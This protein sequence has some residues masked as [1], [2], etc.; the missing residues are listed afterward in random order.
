MGDAVIEDVL[1]R[2]NIEG[3]RR[4]REW[5]APC[6]NKEHVDRHPSWRIRD[7]PG[8][9]R[10]GMHHCWP[11][12]FGGALDDLVMKVLNLTW[13]EAKEWLSGGAVE[14]DK[15]VAGGVEFKVQSALRAFHLPVGVELDP[16]DKWPSSVRKYAQGR[17]ITAE[18]VHHWGIGYAVEGRLGGR[19]VFVKR[20]NRGKDAGYSARTFVDAKN[21]YYEPQPWEKAQLG[22][23][24][25]E[26][27][28][29]MVSNRHAATLYVVEGVIN[30]L[31]IERVADYPTH[32]AVTSGS[33]LHPLHA[34]KISG[35]GKIVIVTDP[36]EAGDKLAAAIDAALSRHRPDYIRVRLPEGQDAASLP[37]EKL[38]EALR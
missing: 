14:L 8:A 38:M 33:Q 37:P 6:P 34:A 25:G 32:V 22:V 28:W 24:F 12:G 19:I 2:L 31:A 36:D 7:E 1:K 21:R 26:Q 27:H 23:M 18:Q 17:G 29:P 30:A 10:H 5:T 20:D 13:S 9:K 4:G 3:R 35:F 15:P 16:F 11:C